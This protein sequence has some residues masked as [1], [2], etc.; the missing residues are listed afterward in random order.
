MKT[1]QGSEIE[2]SLHAGPRRGTRSEMNPGR[3]PRVTQVLALALSFEHMIA[4]G[5]ARNYR[6]LA[7][8]S[9]VST[10]RLSQVMQLIWLA[11]AIQEEILWLPASGTRHPLTERAVRSIAARWSWSEQ[12]KLWDSLKKE[13]HLGT[14]VGG[15]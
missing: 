15:Q 13:L 1:N 3:R 10:Q 7:I 4:T 11:P 9:G 12:L 14:A 5:S 8:R 2:F 6:D